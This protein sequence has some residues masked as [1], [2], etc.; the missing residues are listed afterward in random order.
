VIDL[1]LLWWSAADTSSATICV[2]KLSMQGCQC[3]VVMKL[4]CAYVS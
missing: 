1:K 2:G 3:G 4:Y